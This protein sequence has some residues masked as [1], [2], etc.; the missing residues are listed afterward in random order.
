MRFGGALTAAVFAVVL[1]G[2]NA[3]SAA[4]IIVDGQADIFLAGQSSVPSFTGGAGLLP[5]SFAVIG[6]DTLNITASGLINCCS[7]APNVGPDGAA[8]I[9]DISAYGNVGAYS[10]PV[11]PLVGAFDVGSQWAVFVIGSDLSGLVVPVGATEL[12]LGVPD[13]LG[14]NDAPGYYSDNS[15]SF[16]VNIDSVGVVATSAVPEPLTLSIL[17]AGLVGAAAMRRRKTAKA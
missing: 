6:G 16:T 9:S 12:Y 11:T 15:G 7:G 13:A 3:A 8:G 10:G 1:F 17:G 4:T 14:F 5:P 2:A